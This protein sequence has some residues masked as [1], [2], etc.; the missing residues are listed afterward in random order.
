MQF[1]PAVDRGRLLASVRVRY[2]LSA[3]KLTFVPVGFAAA[4]YV[5]D[6]VG[7]EQYFLKLWPTLAIGSAAGERQYASLVLTRALYDRGLF[8]RVPYP[9][10][11]IGGDL[12][13]NAGGAPFALFPLLPG[14]MLPT[15]TPDY[16][17]EPFG[18]VIAAIHRATPLL[19]DVLPPRETF[20]IP[21]EAGLARCLAVVE[22]I[23]A[24]ERPG[25]RGLRSLVWPRQADI[26]AQHARLRHLQAAVRRLNGPFVLCHTDLGG[27]NMLVDERRQL[28]VLDWDDASV[29][30]PEFDLWSVIGPGFSAVLDTYRSAGG[31]ETLH[32]EHFAFYLL[33][34][35]LGDM[36]ARLERLLDADTGEG[37]DEELL[38]G[39]QAYGFARWATLD[40]TLA[41]VKVALLRHDAA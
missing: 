7:G 16:L 10:P 18:Q 6:C 1:E 38:R 4:C 20:A 30:P 27:A 26:L 29:A 33:R 11:A 15:R 17:L 12:W 2:G 21:D 19:S 13:A 5:L 28:S 41:E 25:L 35:Y 22:R 39:M 9:I 36:T 8:T 23:G 31:A 24:G 37:E 14:R 40:E 3:R 32:L 34:R